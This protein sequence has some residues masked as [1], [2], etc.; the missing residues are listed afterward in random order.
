MRSL[1]PVVALL[2]AT[3]VVPPPVCAQQ[4]PDQ[5]LAGLTLQMRKLDGV[6]RVLMIGAHPDD[7][8]TS[9]LAALARGSGAE[10]AY[11]S[12]S[13]G[14][15]GQNVIGP[16]LHEGLGIVRTGELL[17][18]RELDGGAQ[19]F[20]RA[21]DFGYSKN[22]E[23]ALGHWPMEDVLRDVVFV[24]RT[25]RPHV[26]ISVFSGTPDDGHGHHQVAGVAAARAFEEAGDPDRFPE[27]AAL[28]AEPWAPLKLY[29]GGRFSPEDANT[30]VDTG[31][32]DP[33]LGR[34]W[35]QVAMES[36]SQHRSQDMGMSQYMGPRETSLQL[37]AS[38]VADDG[39]D[40]SVFAGI[41][42]TFA[43]QLPDPLPS[44][45]PSDA[46]ERLERYRHHIRD[47]EAQLSAFEPYRAAPSL[48]EARAVLTRLVEG[49]QG[50]A[51]RDLIGDRVDHLSEAV[52]SAAG[53][54][55]DVRTSRDLITPGEAVVVDVNLWNGGPYAVTDVTPALDL[56]DGWTAT[57]TDRSAAGE[58]RSF[59][60]RPEVAETPADG[61]VVSGAIAR[62]SWEVRLPAG[63]AVSEPYY[64]Q[65]PRA[66]DLYTWPDDPTVWARPFEDPR[67][68]ADVT[69]SLARP[70][71]AADPVQVV[72]AGEYVGVD[73][74][75]GEYREPALVV[76]A[77]SLAV[78]PQRM[79]WPAGSEGSRVVTVIVTNTSAAEREGTVRLDV[80]AGF[81]AEPEETPF[82]LA[83]EGTSRV[84]AFEVVPSGTVPEGD[85]TFR[86]VATA[87]D[88]TRFDTGHD[89]ID[90][91]H[92]R[93]AALFHP[94][95]VSVSAFPVVADTE[96]RVGYIMGSGDDGP[97]ALAQMGMDVDLLTEEAVREGRFDA[98][99]V[100]VLGV[101]AYETR[102]DLVQANDEVLAFA[103]RGGTV[104][105]QYNR[106]PYPA[107]G[108]APY[109]VE[110]SRP[111]DRVTDETAEVHLLEPDAPVFQAP[112]R[113][114]A[115]DFEGWV[116]ERGLY[117]LGNWDE[118]YRP[119]M[120]MA[121]P[122]EEPKAGSLVVAPLGEGLFVYTGLS[123]FRQFP[124]GVPGAYRLFANLVSMR[125]QDWARTFSAS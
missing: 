107:G 57:P 3:L 94:S 48:M 81:R 121:D 76:P 68:R 11:L 35:F 109:P 100:L 125:A 21:F 124:A 31:H 41:D 9:L 19:F 17:A 26:I 91:P 42:T 70:D 14:E 122:G 92:I 103:R 123:F 46:H 108:Y 7:E 28:G 5:G 56:P 38:R 73:P 82:T 87:A 8:D 78:E 10:T 50:G 51:A 86:A 27:L 111:H 55:V 119:V 49:V 77:L 72:R 98:H 115:A 65:Q 106:Y 62:W 71:G 24:V 69:L 110:M 36:R 18:A 114:T 97:S 39:P 6:K 66:G 47:A 1:L 99:D 93:R 74:V 16:E 63:A 59:F 84:F 105:V 20:S 32:L 43:G 44:G 22:I 96:L 79:I 23:E 34:S 67:V 120:E 15:G 85:F 102:P 83:P 75:I 90:Y 61:R 64:L 112:N 13:R 29:R 104:I 12:L 37:M 53:V 101:L 58:P 30:R 2:L 33:V 60:F 4:R 54:V 118:R 113:I 116:Q 52:L 95:T 117:F 88:G 80:G 40:R 25:F 89:V 45:W